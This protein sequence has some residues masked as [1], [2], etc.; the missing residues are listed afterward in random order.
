MNAPVLIVDDS[1]T[2]RMNLTEVLEAAG[3]SAA[4]CATGVEARKAL[5][6]DRFA[7]VIL[8][9][10]LPDVDGVELLRE[11]REAPR[12]SAIPVILLSTEAEVRHRI[13]GL[14]TGADE[15]IGKPYDPSY[16]IARA[17]ELIRREQ[18]ADA[19]P[20]ETILIIDDSV[21][22]REELKEALEAVSYGVL[23]A[24]TGEEGLKLAADMRPS[25]IVIDGM[26]PG[27]DGATVVRRVRLDAA[28]RR[29]PCV[30]LTA[31]ED[32]GAE[33]RALDACHFANGLPFS[34]SRV[35]RPV[36]VFAAESTEGVLMASLSV[37]AFG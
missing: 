8:D 10:L 35:P 17:R 21:T 23:V 15:Y 7:L 32:L 5:A 29:T 27:I 22:F 13:R 14:T 26:L 25:G 18:P 11:I 24:G 12:T 20:R 33:I 30:L 4:P 1:L 37:G 2:V 36:L 16:V 19:L 9:V 3:L 6:E 28:L 34:V 31:S